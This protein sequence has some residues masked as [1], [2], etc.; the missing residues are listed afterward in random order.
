MDAGAWCGCDTA[1]V[2]GFRFELRPL[3]EVE[4]WGDDPPSLSWFGLTDGWY[5]IEA[6][7]HE[8]LRRSGVDGPRPYVDYQVVRLWE[9]VI[10]LTPA[11]LEPVSED[12][13]AFIASEPESWKLD[14]LE[15]V[16]VADDDADP[17]A[18]D[19]PVVTAGLWHGDHYLDMIHLGNPARL[20]F[21]RT[22]HGGSDEM[23]LDWR[24]DDD[25][26]IGF[27]AGSPVRLSFPTS[28]Y[29]AAVRTFDREL[30]AAM[31][32]RVEELDRRG[33]LPGVDIDVPGLR[34]EHG[35]REGWL[36]RHLARSP[37]TDWA[38]IR[39]GAAQLLGAA[40][41][42]GAVPER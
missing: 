23:T 42:S 15:Y 32:Q 17:D 1:A 14:M 35:N 40:E 4:P 13:L 11:V 6:G 31:E 12:L 16:R 33:G 18:P 10:L 26:R 9:D 3:D 36:A 2:I 27:T 5:W 28:E 29:V 34:R 19:H 7:G 38:A 8:L 25:G 24:H 21:W 20:R 41:S 39:Q 22:I 30:L 37:K